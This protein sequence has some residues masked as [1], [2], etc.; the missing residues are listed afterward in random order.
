MNDKIR[1]LGPNKIINFKKLFGLVP[2]SHFFGFD[3]I[4][5]TAPLRS[6]LRMCLNPFCFYTGRKARA[7]KT[8][9]QCKQL[10][11]CVMSVF[12][13]WCIKVEIPRKDNFSG[14]EE[15]SNRYSSLEASRN[16]SAILCTLHKV[17]LCLVLSTLSCVHQKIVAVSFLFCKGSLQTRQENSR[18]EGETTKDNSQAGL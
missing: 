14:I 15:V 5:D 18:R 12:Q 16:F 11:H 17:C 6:W 1:A 2:S 9:D 13:I 8:N 10:H 3:Q 4:D 7:E